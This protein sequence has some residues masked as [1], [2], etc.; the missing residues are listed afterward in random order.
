MSHAHLKECSADRS[1]SSSSK[2]CRHCGG[3]YLD[4]VTWQRADK[5]SYTTQNYCYICVGGARDRGVL[6][7]VFRF[8][9]RVRI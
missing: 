9:D 4:S 5:S 1:I 6:Y 8:S 2:Y 3:P 7:K